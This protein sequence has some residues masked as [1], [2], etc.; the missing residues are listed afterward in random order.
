MT[1]SYAQGERRAAVSVVSSVE[2]QALEGHTPRSDPDTTD[3]L[4][5]DNFPP[6]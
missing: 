1:R 4:I 5:I 3:L 6:D 2:D